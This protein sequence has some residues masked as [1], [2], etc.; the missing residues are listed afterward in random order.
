MWL[1]PLFL[2]DDLGSPIFL[3]FFAGICRD[4]RFRVRGRTKRKK[5]IGSSLH[6]FGRRSR[7]R[8]FCSKYFLC[9]CYCFLPL[10]MILM[11]LMSMF[12]CDRFLRRIAGWRSLHFSF[13]FIW[14]YHCIPH[15][16]LSIWFSCLEWAVVPCQKQLSLNSAT[17]ST[18]FSSWIGVRL[19]R[20]LIFAKSLLF[21]K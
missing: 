4:S 17:C 2:R 16:L 15:L 6:L 12:L 20:W 21:R 19:S 8:S 10:Y 11:G 5:M 13:F 14:I 3:S 1:G 9:H 18:K 7:L